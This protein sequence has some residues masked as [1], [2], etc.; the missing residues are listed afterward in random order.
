[1]AW[2]WVSGIGSAIG[3]IAGALGSSSAADAQVAAE[4]RAMQIQQQMFNQQFGALA[5]QR[6]A[7]YNALNELG[8]LGSGP[9]TQYNAQGQ[10]TGQGIGSGYLTHQFGNEDLNAN[11]SPNYR[12]QLEQG[13]GMVNNANNAIGGRIGGNALQGLNQFNQNFAGNA[14]QQ[15]FNN[16]QGQR[17]NIYNT[18]AGIAGIGQNALN[19]GAQVGMN[20]ANAMGQ[21]QVGMGNA[22]ASGYMG[23]GNAFGGAAQGIGNSYML[24]QLLNQRSTVN[25]YSQLPTLPDT[26]VNSTDNLSGYVGGNIA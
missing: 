26:N 7:G 17:N 22:L 19:T 13:Q 18:L 2:G 24:S 25:P 11:I 1:M 20:A 8:A 9:Y 21:Q 10:S 4:M 3:G 23:M 16:Y 15:A 14:Y 6:A 12:F 5:P